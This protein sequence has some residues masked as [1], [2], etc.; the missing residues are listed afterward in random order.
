MTKE[1]KLVRKTWKQTSRSGQSAIVAKHRPV[2]EPLSMASGF[3]QICRGAPP[4]RHALE[5]RKGPYLREMEMAPKRP[6]PKKLNESRGGIA[7][8]HGLQGGRKVL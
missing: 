5:R 2:G 4:Q 7:S 3:A 1:A 8:C 6:G